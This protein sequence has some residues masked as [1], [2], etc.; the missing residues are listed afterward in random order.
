[1][2]VRMY[3]I[4]QQSGLA[5]KVYR[6]NRLPRTTLTAN[7]GKKFNIRVQKDYLNCPLATLSVKSFSSKPYARASFTS[8]KI[9]HG[10]SPARFC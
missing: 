7:H 4:P 9:A 6:L 5:D 2:C 10:G 8:A 3:V 1:M